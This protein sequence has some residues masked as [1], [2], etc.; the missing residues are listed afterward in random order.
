YMKKS[1]PDPMAPGVCEG[2]QAPGSPAPVIAGWPTGFIPVPGNSKF[3]TSNFCVM[4]Y[5]AKEVGG[6]AVSQ[7]EGL[8]WSLKRSDARVEAEGACSGCRLMSMNEWLTIAHN[9]L[10]VPSNWSGGSVGSGYVFS[11][12]DDT[13][14]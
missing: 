5:E 13:N 9:A 14:I 1:G 7:P 11:G 10:N 4:K 8:P 6:I 2:H 12:H 3:G